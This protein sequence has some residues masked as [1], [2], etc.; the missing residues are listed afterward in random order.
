MAIEVRIPT[1]LRTHTGG[2]KEVHA[3]GAT[4][5]EVIDD[6]EAHYPGLKARLVD[7]SGLRR[8][9]NVYVND[10]DIRLTGGLQ[11]WLAAGTELRKP[12][13]DALRLTARLGRA[14]PACR[15]PAPVTVPPGAAVGKAGGP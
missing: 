7:E 11:R 4:L 14:H 1:I 12:G 3:E 15:A 5:A 13:Q 9:V 8:F 2:A 10:K 6:L